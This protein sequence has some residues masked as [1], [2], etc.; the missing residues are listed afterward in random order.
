MP[1]RRSLLIVAALL[2]VYIVLGVLYESLAHPLTIIST[3]PSAGLGAL[4]ALQIF[5]T[6]L[7]IIAFIGIILLIG[8]VKKNGIMMVDFALEGER[9]RGLPPE[10]AIHEACLARF[11]PILM[12]TMS[13]M[14][15]AVPLV[16]A[17]GPGS[18]L[19]RPLGITIIG[20][21]VVS[22]VLTLY[23]TP[24]IYLLLDRLHRRL[25]GGSL[26]SLRG[27]LGTRPRLG[28]AE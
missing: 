26:L 12:T 20:G 19:R 1:A 18:E 9:Q 24:V 11:R 17:T 3:L 14:L 27:V 25:G 15:G 8:I 22:Q 16:V 7:S 13:A 4:L 28:P 2:A 6:E 10:Q 21:L 23:T 5:N